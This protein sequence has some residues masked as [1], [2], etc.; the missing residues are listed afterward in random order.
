MPANPFGQVDL[1]EWVN[2]G[3]QSQASNVSPLVDVLKKRMGQHPTGPFNPQPDA[4]YSD[5]LGGSIAKPKTG[6]KPESL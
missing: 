4:S 2:M 5:L 3:G 6:M 1:P